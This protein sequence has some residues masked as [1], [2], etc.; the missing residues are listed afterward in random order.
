MFPLKKSIYQMVEL[1]LFEVL[2][3]IAILAFNKCPVY[4]AHWS[5][6]LFL[7]IEC[8]AFTCSFCLVPISGEHSILF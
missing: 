3:Y 1:S 2:T 4:L 7:F 5:N 6:D 8:L